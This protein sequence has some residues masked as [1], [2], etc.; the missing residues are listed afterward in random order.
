M[1]VEEPT[2]PSQLREK[3]SSEQIHATA[4]THKHAITRAHKCTEL[5][6][7]VNAREHTNT[8][9]Q[10]YNLILT[11][12]YWLGVGDHISREHH[13]VIGWCQEII[14]I[15]HAGKRGNLWFPCHENLLRH[16]QH[17]EYRLVQWNW[18]S[19]V[20]D[21]CSSGASSDHREPIS[22]HQAVCRVSKTH[23]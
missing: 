14:T 11:W 10:G 8:L 6:T 16:Q 22:L 17:P 1:F 4:P 7:C 3:H 20:T 15:S 5:R 19:D 12:P 18:F 9:Q 23:H 2:K 13:E 21:A